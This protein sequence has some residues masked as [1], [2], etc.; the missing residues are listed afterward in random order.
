MFDFSNL[1]FLSPRPNQVSTVIPYYEK[2][3]HRWPTVEALAAA[4]LEEVH[5]M[6]AGLGYYSRGR[7]LWEAAKK[8]VEEMGG[9]GR[10]VGWNGREK[11]NHYISRWSEGKTFADTDASV[12]IVLQGSQCQD[13]LTN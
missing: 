10:T 5:E 11:D 8:V 3:V 12:F 9:Q 4:T 13:I 7:R 6:W 1:I 2:W